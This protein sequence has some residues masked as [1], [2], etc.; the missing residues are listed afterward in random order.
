MSESI[1]DNMEKRL[2]S[3]LTNA[4]LATLASLIRPIATLTEIFF[5]KEM[6]ERYFTAWNVIGGLMMIGFVRMPVWGFDDRDVRTM[7]N[8][9]AGIWAVCLILY[10]YAN[11]QEMIKR[12]SKGKAWHSYN[13]GIPSFEKVG[14]IFEKIIPAVLGIVMYYFGVKSIGGLLVFSVMASL[15][16]R[17]REAQLFREQMFNAIDSRIEQENLQ[18]AIVEN[19]PPQQTEGLMAYVPKYMGDEMR[20][21]IR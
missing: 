21:M 10:S 9:F 6:G 5:R 12:Y 3:A 16:L 11:R 18:K 4:L 1:F 15:W 8:I 14:I 7:T 13:C 20:G 19:L 17:Y 2:N